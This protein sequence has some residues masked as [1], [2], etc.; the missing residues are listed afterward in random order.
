MAA[1]SGYWSHAIGL[2]LLIITA[3][4]RGARMTSEPVHKEYYR[5]SAALAVDA[6]SLSVL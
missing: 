1:D 3:G 4:L 2:L 6:S 5:Q